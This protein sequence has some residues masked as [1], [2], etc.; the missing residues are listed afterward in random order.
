MTEEGV[1]MCRDSG[2]PPAAVVAGRGCRP[3][4]RPSPRRGEG[5]SRRRPRLPFSPPARGRGRGR[6]EAGRYGGLPC[7]HPG[8]V[9]GSRLSG[10]AVAGPPRNAVRGRPGPRN[11]SGH[12]GGRGADVPGFGPSTGRGHSRSRRAPLTPALS[13]A[14]RGRVAAATPPPLLPS[15]SRE[16]PGEGGGRAV[17]GSPPLSPRTCSGVQTVGHRCSRASPDRGPGQAWTPEQVRA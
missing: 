11:E 8:L 15:R 1:P 16:G 9:P 10:T 14:G 7:C 13:P 4:P 6:A 2:L 3:S 12:D 17:R 5:E